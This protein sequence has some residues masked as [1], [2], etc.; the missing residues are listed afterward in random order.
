MPR[1]NR[2]GGQEPGSVLL[3]HGADHD[4]GRRPAVRHVLIEPQLRFRLRHVRVAPGEVHET[5]RQVDRDLIRLRAERAT[6][7][8]AGRVR[9]E[10]K[11]TTHRRIRL[12][13]DAVGVIADVGEEGRARAFAVYQLGNRRGNLA[14]RFGHEGAIIGVGRG[15]NVAVV[16]AA[17]P[18]QAGVT[19]TRA[20]RYAAVVGRRIPEHVKEQAVDLVAVQRFG[21]NR[22]R[23]L[24]VVVAV[25]ARRIQAVVDCRLTVGAPE[26]P[27]RVRV[28]CRLL[29][30]A[31]VE[32][33]DDAHATS[34]SVAQDVT[35]K[36]AARRQEGAWI[37]KR[38]ARRVL[39]DDA[40]HVH[41][42]RV[43]ANVRDRAHQLMRIDRRIG[44]AQVGLEEPNRFGHPPAGVR[45]CGGA[46]RT[47]ADDGR[48][49]ERRR[50]ERQSE[51]GDTHANLVSHTLTGPSRG[52]FQRSARSG[53]I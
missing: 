5:H 44:L 46:R 34:V 39:R 26:E 11:R 40:A 36:I 28:V 50:G 22:Q 9:P 12:G 25:D 21:E 53:I 7:V 49:R 42:E 13:H 6:D 17:E 38:H 43:G 10:R 52:G 30:L 15:G 32:A 2:F 20:H 48:S 31:Q 33:A 16:A 8:V 4:D 23:V 41:E 24:A 3:R 27:L 29:S 18:R 45:R 19:P 14:G 37:V 47:L 35:K 51:E 1:E